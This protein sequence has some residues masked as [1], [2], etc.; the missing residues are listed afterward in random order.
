MCSPATK[1]FSRCLH[2]RWGLG[3]CLFILLLLL[4]LW[5]LWPCESSRASGLIAHQAYV[6]Q[7]S[8]GPQ[9]RD[10][11]SKAEERLAG[12][13]ALGAEVSWEGGRP[14]LA[15]VEWDPAFLAGLKT[16]VGLA[17]RVGPYPGPFKTDDQAG[18]TL[19]DV[20]VSLIARA[21]DAGLSVCELQIDFDCAESKLDGYGVWARSIR[22]R[23]APVPLV[24][25]ALPSWLNHREFRTLAEAA[26]GFVLQVH[27]LER[28]KGPDAP[29]TLCDPAAA[30]RAVERAAGFGRPF[31][32]AL[33]TYGYRVAFDKSGK[34]IGISAEGPAGRWPSDA[35]VAEI[36]SDPAA[37]A[38][39]VQAW[40]ADRPM[41]LAG[42]IWYRLPT[43]NDA[44]N[45]RWPTLECVMTGKRPLPVVR[46][47]IRRPEAGLVKI[48]LVNDG[49][50]DLLS[51]IRLKIDCDEADLIAGDA[52]VGFQWMGMTAGT[53]TVES[54]ETAGS[55]V[56]PAGERQ[57]AVWLRL[58]QDKEVR[59]E[60]ETLEP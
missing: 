19:A 54:R 34:F 10:S 35:H 56:L 13:V 55:R 60:I 39:L 36:R 26:D 18:R 14:L 48:D 57:A 41:N 44:F 20:A 16:P 25:T 42:I 24:I 29:M 1:R 27:S 22:Q 31:R 2:V 37:M 59:V 21:R 3:V 12:I 6:W 49:Q 46:A 45:W 38:D 9:V 52:L 32:V 50:A 58:S 4:A 53:L 51:R 40:T 8:W 47:D 43:D 7:R 5:T 30:R 15:T 17:M 33:P 11:I 28:P 23:I